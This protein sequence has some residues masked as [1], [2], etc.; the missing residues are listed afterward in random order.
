LGD[1][2]SLEDIDA[3]QKGLASTPIGVRRRKD[4]VQLIS[5]EG[6][7]AGAKSR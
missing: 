3:S 2:P 4:N 5:S 1:Y 6:V 7:V